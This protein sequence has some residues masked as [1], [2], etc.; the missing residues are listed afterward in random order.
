MSRKHLSISVIDQWDWI[1]LLFDKKFLDFDAKILWKL[2]PPLFFFMK[3]LSF[4][5]S[6]VCEI[7]HRHSCNIWLCIIL[8]QNLITLIQQSRSQYLWVSM[9]FSEFI[10][11]NPCCNALPDVQKVIMDNSN[12]RPSSNYHNLLLMQ[13]WFG[14]KFA[15]LIKIKPLI[16]SF[17]III[18]GPIFITIVYSVKKGIIGVSQKEHQARF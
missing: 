17:T 8:E 10:A 6:Q 13:L 11:V 15:G 5:H 14:E 2:L 18:H 4:Q 12:C 7:L 16:R 3:V 9:H 1:Y